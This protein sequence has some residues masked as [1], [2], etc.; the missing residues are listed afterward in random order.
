MRVGN[1]HK[2]ENKPHI[3][4][5]PEQLDL[6]QAAQNKD[7]GSGDLNQDAQSQAEEFQFFVSTS[8]VILEIKGILLVLLSQTSA[9]QS[10]EEELWCVKS[11]HSLLF[12]KTRE[13][14]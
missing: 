1:E 7:Q 11:Q 6:I 13:V 9:N 4:T 8:W 12:N 14:E 10:R 5:S 3:C 2:R